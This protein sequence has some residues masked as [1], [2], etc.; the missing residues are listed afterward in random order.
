MSEA[1]PNHDPATGEI[2][3]TAAADGSQRYPAANTLTDLI[4][5]LSDGQFNYDCSADLQKMAE[6]MEELGID[7]GGKVK[8]K[9]V[10]SIEVERSNDGIYF[11]TPNIDVKLPKAK[12][13]RTIGWV[14]G[15]NKFTPNKPN[16]G[17]LF[18]TIRDV[19]A[20]APKVRN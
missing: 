3:E 16:Q 17:N 2:I 5:M 9:V 8:G 12:G 15:D 18:G 14:T 11:F 20:G 13:R 6:D 4:H 1:L 7:T 19:S 10:V